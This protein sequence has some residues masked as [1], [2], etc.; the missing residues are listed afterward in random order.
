MNKELYELSYSLKKE[1]R[2]R[3]LSIVCMLV[4]VY[5][6]INLILAF[7]VFP[8]RQVSVSMESDVGR[9]SCIMFSPLKKHFGRGA[10]VLVNPLDSEDV[11]FLK[12]AGSSFVSFVLFIQ[13]PPS[14]QMCVQNANGVLCRYKDFRQSCKAWLQRCQQHL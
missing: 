1:M 7:V 6:V 2:Q 8:V 14:I 13:M 12:K 10:V 5:I 4:A 3:V 9:N 11:P